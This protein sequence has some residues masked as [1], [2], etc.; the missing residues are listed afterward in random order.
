MSDKHLIM[1]VDDEPDLMVMVT[2]Y[3]KA[4]KFETEGYTDPVKALDAFQSNPSRYS[5][6]LTDVRMP[7]ISGIELAR[8]ILAIKPDAQVVIMTAYEVTKEML[9]GV[10]VVR[11]SEI[12]KKP[13]RLAEICESVR[14]HLQ[15]AH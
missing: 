10:P 13:F 12:L 2:R 7:Q 15:I 14:R 6:V 11:H 9:V 8:R 1:V 4:W 3:L 5:M